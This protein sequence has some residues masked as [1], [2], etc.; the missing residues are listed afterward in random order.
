MLVLQ[1]LHCTYVQ[2]GYGSR[3][4]DEEQNK[5]LL[6]A[7]ILLTLPLSF[8]YI[9]CECKSIPIRMI[10]LSLEVTMS[11]VTGGGEGGVLSLVTR[12]SAPAQTHPCLVTLTISSAMCAVSSIL[13]AHLASFLETVQPI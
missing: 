7:R 3:N 5:T 12:L 6:E 13:Q 9:S 1:C 4:L 11:R 10:P 2:Y 8:A